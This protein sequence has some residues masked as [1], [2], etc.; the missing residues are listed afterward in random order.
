MKKMNQI[1][2]YLRILAALA[3]SAPS[4]PVPARGGVPAIFNY[5]GKLAATSGT[6]ANGPIPMAFRIYNDLGSL[7]TTYTPSGPITVT[8]G[9]FS[10]LVGDLVGGNIVGSALDQAFSGAGDRYL[11]VVVDGNAMAPR[12]RLV[13]VPYALSVADGSVGSDLLEDGDVQDDDIAGM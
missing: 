2:R 8:N 12:Q 7:L 5:Q 4:I 1:Q 10:V 6:P 9:V 13:A 3:V 11:E